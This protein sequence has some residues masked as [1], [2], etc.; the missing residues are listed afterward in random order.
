MKLSVFNG[1]L[2]KIGI[3][4]TID[5][6]LGG[7]RES[8][9]KQTMDQ[10]KA[11]AKLI[12]SML[13]Y[14]NG[15]PVECVIADTCIGGVAEAAACAE[16]FAKAGVG[17]SLTVT[18]CWCYGSETMD[19]NPSVPKAVWGF[20]G[21]ERPGAVYLAAVLAG[22][23]QKG[24]PAFSIYGREVQDGGDKSIPTDVQEKIL[25]FV[26]AGLAVA[27]MRGK[28]YLGMGG[29]S[30]GIAGS[31]VDQPFFEDYLGM[32]V[33]TIDM[34]EFL[35]RMDKGIFDGAEYAKALAWV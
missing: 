35:R 16:K 34:T 10:A 13:R 17:V 20:N 22:H 26:R 2:P 7:V 31:I 15:Q 6:R 14:P 29:V 28:S 5:G 27:L 33:E 18:P 11:A 9:E 23:S 8:L 25:R 19:M 1:S 32:R 21:T 12:S 3:R 4:P 24:I 30:M